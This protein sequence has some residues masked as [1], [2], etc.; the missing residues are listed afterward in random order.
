ME[1]HNP[2]GFELSLINLQRFARKQMSRNRIGR[3]R[4]E[5]KKIEFLVR[6][7]KNGETPVAQH[8]IASASAARQ[9]RKETLCDEFHLRI[10]F[11]KRNPSIGLCIRGNR[12]RSETH[13]ADVLIRTILHHRHD[14]AERAVGKVIR[15]RLPRAR[16]IKSFKS[17]HGVA[18]QQ[19][20]LIVL[21]FVDH[22]LHAEK[23]AGHVKALSPL[24]RGCERKCAGQDKHCQD[25]REHPAQ[26]MKRKRDQSDEEIAGNGPGV[27][28]LQFVIEPLR[29]APAC[30]NRDGREER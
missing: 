8:D 9:K 27:F 24:D 22:L 17:M 28:H 3:E 1:R 10:D 29:H 23:I 18:V 12:S 13:N 2:I 25:R 26:P 16:R 7:P 30:C 19:L 4:I 11:E 5:D 21:D 6:S 14:V 20:A 15:Q